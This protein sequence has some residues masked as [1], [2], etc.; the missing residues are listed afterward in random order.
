MK[1]TTAILGTVAFC[2]SGVASFPAAVFEYT[3]KAEREALSSDEFESIMTK[4]FGSRQTPG[5]NATEQY[6]S[7]SGHY[8]YVA[9]DL[10][11]DQRGPCPGLNAM[12]NHGY[13]PH[14]G[15][16]TIQEFIDGAYNGKSNGQGYKTIELTL[17]SIWY[18]NRSWCIF[19]YLWRCHRWRSHKMVHWWPNPLCTRCVRVVG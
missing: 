8:A 17:P 5:F 11:N 2:V 3:S 19:V 15:V 9:P 7:T 14:N 1:Y 18:G 10:S 12:A 13:I 6:V 4:F 16:A